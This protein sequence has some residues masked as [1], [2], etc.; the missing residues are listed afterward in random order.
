MRGRPPRSSLGVS[1]RAILAQRRGNPTSARR[2]SG[3]PARSPAPASEIELRQR[4]AE[5]G[6]D[7]PAHR[8]AQLLAFF[9]FFAF[10]VIRATDANPLRNPCLRSFTDVPPALARQGLDTRRTAQ[11]QGC[12]RSIKAAPAHASCNP[13]ARL[14]PHP[15]VTCPPSAHQALPTE[16]VRPDARRDTR[17]AASPHRP[18]MRVVERRPAKLDHGNPLHCLTARDL[19]MASS[20]TSTSLHHAPAGDCVAFPH[21]ERRP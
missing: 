13:A 6:R 19:A 2:L 12:T 3:R 17:R 14:T 21:R 11:N 10:R 4:D 1:L 5:R 16:S 20:T 18:R 7:L 8:L 15:P 9:A